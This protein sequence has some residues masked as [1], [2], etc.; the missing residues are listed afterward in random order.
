MNYN[1]FLIFSF[2]HVKSEVFDKKKRTIFSMRLCFVTGGSLADFVLYNAEKIKNIDV[3]IFSYGVNG[4]IDFNGEIT[5][6]SENLIDLAKISLNFDC[7]V[8]AGCDT[9]NY[10]VLR[11]S[12]AVADKGRIL[13]VC[14]M[15]HNIDGEKYDA[16]SG[17][18]VF[19][20]SK[21]KIGVIVDKDLY[22]PEVSNILSLSESDIIINVL[23]KV[24]DY[25]PLLMLRSSSFTSGVKIAACADNFC[26]ISDIKANLEFFSTKRLEIVDTKIVKEYRLVATRKRAY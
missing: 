25:L 23:K 5:G 6:K 20:T 21:G 10:G 1:K 14:D 9:D 15:T 8:V 16:G 13:G 17:C 7:V 22:F 4:L 2:L 12:A 3:V 11:C 24:K 26:A 18:R 19:N